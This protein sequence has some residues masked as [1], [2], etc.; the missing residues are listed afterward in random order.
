MK[1]LFKSM[2]EREA[3]CCWC[4]SIVTNKVIP[5]WYMKMEK[6]EF[7]DKEFKCPDCLE[8]IYMDLEVRIE[9]VFTVRYKPSG[10]WSKDE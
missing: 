4:G 1:P 7:K 6:D 9:H 2:T 10:E 8:S 5:D 3:H